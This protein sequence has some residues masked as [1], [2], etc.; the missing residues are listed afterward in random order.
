MQFEC[1]TACAPVYQETKKTISIIYATNFF[2]H[3]FYCYDSEYSLAI[4]TITTSWG[5]ARMRSSVAPQRESQALP[6][7]AVML[8]SL[9]LSFH[10]LPPT[11]SPQYRSNNKIPHF[12]G[13]LKLAHKQFE[14]DGRAEYQDRID[15]IHYHIL[16]V[17]V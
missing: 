14:N 17:I 13:I 12:F 6:S 15:V 9:I 2:S 4:R 3:N 8:F 11:R 16:L 1:C 7:P 5:I 10:S